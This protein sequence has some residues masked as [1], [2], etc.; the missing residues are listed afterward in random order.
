MGG[1]CSTAVL[2][3]DDSE[4]PPRDMRRHA[5]CT[6]RAAHQLTI[7]NKKQVC[8]YCRIMRKEDK[9]VIDVKPVG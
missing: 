9:L 1:S 4:V 2:S 8:D 3:D 5:H 7:L 6:V